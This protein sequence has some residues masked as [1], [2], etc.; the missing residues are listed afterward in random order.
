MPHENYKKKHM[1]LR[2]LLLVIVTLFIGFASFAQNKGQIT[3]QIL[4]AEMNNESLPFANVFIKNTQIGGTTDLDGKYNFSVGEGTYTLVFS[5]IG[6]QTIEVENVIVTTNETIEVNDVTLGASEGV[7]LDEVIV[8]GNTTKESES[9]L[10]GVQ[11]KAVV[12]KESIG[13]QR[14]SQL[15]ISEAA[16]ATSK[17]SGVTNNE[18]SGDIYIRGLGDRYLSTTMN[19]LPIPSDDVE[20]KNINLDLFS[21]NI[22]QNISV[23]KT[24]STPKYA[25]QASGNIDMATKYS[26]GDKFSIGLNMGTNT[27][28][29]Q[30]DIWNSFKT[31]QNMN[32]VSFGIYNK[33]YALVD[34]ITLQSWNTETKSTP[35]DYKLQFAG[36]KKL[37]LFGHD[38]SIFL[39]ASHSSRNEFYQGIF[40]SYRSNV[41]DQSFSDATQYTTNINTTGYLNL[42]YQLSSD[43]RISYNSLFVN[44]TLDNLYESGRNEEGYVFDQDPS[45][46]GAFIRDQNLK[47]TRMFINQLLGH[48]LL[49]ENNKLEWAAGYNYVWAAEPNRIRNE[50]NILDENTVQFAHVGDFQQ[51]KSSQNIVD[52][53][54]NSYINDELVFKPEADHPF[55]LNIGFNIRQKERDFKSV[56]VGVRAKGVQTNS[57]DDFDD[58]FTQGNFDNGTLIL[59][60]PN[61][62]LYLANL[63]VYAGYANLDFGF[64]KL[65]G[66]VGVRY[67]VDEIYI[68]WDVAN[69]VGRVGSLTNNYNNLF[70]SLNLKY[71]IKENSA[72]RIAASK[73][74]SLPEFKEL[75]PFEYVSPTGRVTAGNPDL[76]ESTNYNIDFKWELFPKSK[77]LVSATAFYKGIIDPINLAQTRGSSGNFSYFNTGERADVF[78]LEFEARFGI[79]ENGNNKLG[80]NFNATKMW[81]NQD[82]FE[83]FQYNNKTSSGLQGASD[84]ILNASLN[85]SN[86]REKEFAATLSGNYS[87]DNV[88]ALGAPEDFAN[89]DVLYNDEIIEKGFFVLDLILRKKFNDHLSMNLRGLNLL[90]PLIEQTQKVKDIPTQIETNETVVSYKNGVDIRIGL[91]YTF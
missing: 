20:K 68:I 50:V 17:I 30:N 7:S 55:K 12:I 64:S 82:L 45:E 37:Q 88:F 34:A 76:K 53:E 63:D 22:I 18:A 31:T 83:E 61:P 44:K 59:R 1:I 47:Q 10:L 57:I 48:H 9:A 8:K 35:V 73:T 21:T 77:E 26:S 78:G 28:V 80:F 38:L 24:Y 36:G 65:T 6:Y 29:M 33:K 13:S 66:N 15:G 60:E 70:P 75:A 16:T 87:S 79:I 89:S 84:F 27:N 4:D 71:E 25:D 56:N 81:F 42:R 43:H 19:N 72:F 86:N 51:R 39:S 62:D 90:N 23:S 91:K 67:E 2:K 74:Q 58:V 11:K 69:Y 52:T 49:S 40:K 5:F 46:D 14:L 3:G 85:Y 41:L 32:D 54:F